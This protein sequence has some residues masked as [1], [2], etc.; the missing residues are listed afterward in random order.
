MHRSTP[1]TSIQD[2]LPDS[3]A[4]HVH[5]HTSGPLTHWLAF[6][7]VVARREDLR[8]AW[9]EGETVTVMVGVKMH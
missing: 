6:F 5:K 9:E 2:S 4:D 8:E 1:A 7:L 3:T